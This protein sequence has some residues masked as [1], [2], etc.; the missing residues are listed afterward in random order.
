MTSVPPVIGSEMKYSL[1]Q[2]IDILAIKPR[3]N[4]LLG[5]LYE[6]YIIFGTQNVLWKHH[7]TIQIK[8]NQPQVMF[9]LM[10]REKKIILQPNHLYEKDSN[11]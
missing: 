4:I 1:L 6:Y 2:V 7:G 3:N 10:Q 9:W 8:F 5:Y 11:S